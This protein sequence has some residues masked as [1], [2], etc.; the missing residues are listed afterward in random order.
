MEFIVEFSKKPVIP[1]LEEYK[2]HFCNGKNHC[3]KIY[4]DTDIHQ[5]VGVRLE[6]KYANIDSPIFMTL[7]KE[8]A[9]LLGKSLLALT[10]SMDQRWTGIDFNQ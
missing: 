1:N 8:E 9:R 7:T 6:Q 3:L 2:K 5:E 10:E 4:D